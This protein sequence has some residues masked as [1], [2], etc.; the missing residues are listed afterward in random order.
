VSPA[1]LEHILKKNWI[2]SVQILNSSNLFPSITLQFLRK[3]VQIMMASVQVWSR[4][5]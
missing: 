4:M 1:E 2:N 5:C 3:S